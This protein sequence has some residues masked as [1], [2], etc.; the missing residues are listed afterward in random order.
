MDGMDSQ[1]RV[2][3][4]ARLGRN[5]YRVLLLDIQFKVDSAGSGSSNFELKSRLVSPCSCLKFMV[6]YSTG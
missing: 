3:N 5:H 6:L 4:L 1:L 2:M